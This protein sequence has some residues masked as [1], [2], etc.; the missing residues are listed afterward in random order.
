M[1]N[2]VV[3]ALL[4]CL[5]CATLV[6]GA[7][8]DKRYKDIYELALQS[9]SQ[10]ISLG[11]HALYLTYLLHLFTRHLTFTLIPSFDH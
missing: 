9:K 2:A 10:I 6:N 7:G 5:F 8:V 1:A 3:I 4:I 11:I